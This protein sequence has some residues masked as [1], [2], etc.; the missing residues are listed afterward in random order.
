MYDDIICMSMLSDVLVHVR[1]LVRYV[2]NFELVT[3]I[4]SKYVY[5]SIL[6]LVMKTN[7]IIYKQAKLAHIGE[8]LAFHFL[9][10]QVIVLTWYHMPTNE[11]IP[12]QHLQPKV[13]TIVGASKKFYY[14]KFSEVSKKLH[15]SL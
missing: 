2:T 7:K 6:D 10:E 9:H 12:L 15:P 13:F 5:I 3:T 14:N 8:A 11:L 1:Q 4:S